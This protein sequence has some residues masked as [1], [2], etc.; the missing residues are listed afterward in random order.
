M[1]PKRF[2]VPLLCLA[3][4]APTAAHAGLVTWELEGTVEAAGPYAPGFFDPAL[5]YPLI[6]QLEAVGVAVGVA[7]WARISFDSDSPGVPLSGYPDAR[8]FDG[9]PTGIEFVS[10]GFAAA[11]PDGAVGRT[12][13][14]D[15]SSDP[16][17]TSVLI[18]DVPMANDS[19]TLLADS[20]TL[21]FWSSD[22]A[23]SFAGSLPSDPPVLHGFFQTDTSVKF[24]RLVGHGFVWNQNLV[25]PS[26]IEHS[27][28]IS[29]SITSIT[30]VP[31]PGSFA[32]VLV[33]SCAIAARRRSRALP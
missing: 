8:E 9:V 5:G 3:L 28:H 4:A 7:W 22:P 25:N 19:S 33:A 11:T 15:L 12:L 26:L 2:A 21:Q 23:I 24:F 14:G 20:A 30:I 27:F 18:F 1:T 6:A 17:F 16:G 13:A 29:G 31:E 10:G 32:L